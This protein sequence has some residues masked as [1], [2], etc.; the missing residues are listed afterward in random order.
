MAWL[1]ALHTSSVQS[2]SYHSKAC[3][4]YS[5]IGAL[6]KHTEDVGAQGW[7]AGIKEANL[8]GGRLLPSS[9]FHVY[10]V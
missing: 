3:I 5:C 4:E 6:L 9:V 8:S 10:E 2:L 1:T 7:S